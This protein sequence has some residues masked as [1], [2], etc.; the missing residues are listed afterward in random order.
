MTRIGKWALPLIVPLAATTLAAPAAAAPGDPSEMG[1]S[2]VFHCQRDAI[3]GLNP[4]VRLLCD[5]PVEV[6]G[7]STAWVRYRT[8]TH[9]GGN[10]TKCQGRLDEYGRYHADGCE[11]STSYT[12]PTTVSKRE[13][14]IVWADA[15][16]DGEPGH[17]E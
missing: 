9:I 16:P 5:S 4:S 15:I 14:Y 1:L 13:R 12:D 10:R 11:L 17:I 8:F 3:L 7:E 2:D 6:T